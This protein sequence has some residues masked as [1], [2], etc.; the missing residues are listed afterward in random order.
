MSEVMSLSVELREQ[1]GSKTASRLREQGKLPAVIYGH[2]QQP[3][4]VALDQH[5]KYRLLLMAV[6]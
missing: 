2:K 6:N 1:V 3:V 5:H 4:S